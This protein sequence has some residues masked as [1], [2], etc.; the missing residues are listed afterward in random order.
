MR[1]G[2][3]KLLRSCLHVLLRA[4]P[5]DFRESYGEDLQNAYVDRF[6]SMRGRGARLA[7][8][9]VVGLA[10]RHSLRDGV[11]E[12]IADR[13]RQR[14]R[15]LES[16]FT[17]VRM[18]LR[19]LRRAPAFTLVAVLILA[20]GVGANVTAFGA[21]RIASLARPPLPDAE[22][23]VSVDLMR[24]REDGPRYS[25]WAYPY[26]QMLIDW[27]D[28]LIDP[29]AG[30]RTQQVTLTDLGPASQVP[31]EMVSSDY[32][33]VVGIPMAIGRGFTAE[34]GD[35]AAGLRAVVVAHGFWQSRL[36]GDQSVLDREIRLNGAAFRVVGVTP[37]GFSGLGGGADLWV[38]HG[39][40]ELVQPGVLEQ[41]YNHVAWVVGRLRPGA[42]LPAAAAQMES[43]GEAVAEGWPR[44][45]SYRAGVRSFIEIWKNPNA[46]KA[47]TLLSVAAALVLLVA[48]ANLSG[49][50][51]TRARRRLREGAVR[52]ALGASRWRLVRSF[53]VESLT[54]AALGSLAGIGVSL[55]GT[56]MLIVAW[57]AEFLRGTDTGLQVVHPDTMSFDASLTMFALAVAAFAA[58]L[59]GLVPALRA[60]SEH[61]TGHLKET[62]DVSGRRRRFANFDAQTTLVGAQICLALMLVVS[63][64]LLG[65]SVKRLLGVDEGFRTE[66]LLTFDY[67]SPQGV[68]RL[69]PTDEAAWRDFIAL[70]A[71]FDDRMKQRFTALPGIEGMAISAAPMLGG[72]QAVVGVTGI[73][74]Q[75][76]FEDARSIGVVTVDD[77]CFETLGIPILRGRGFTASDGLQSE[78]VV[79]LNETAVATYFRDQDP[80]GQ[81]IGIV[82]SLPGRQMA[83]VVGIVGDM[84]HTG[85]DRDRWP[86][87]YFST[88]ERRHGSHAMIRTTGDPAASI[89]MIQNELYAMDPTIAMSNIATMDQLIIQSVGDRTMILVL[90]GMFAGITVLLVAVGTWG[91]VAFSVADRM[92]ELVLRVALGAERFSVVRLVMHKTTVTALVGVAFGLGGAYAGTRI[93]EAFLW[94]TSA[95]DPTTFLLGS[96]FL[97]AVV[98]VASYLPARQATRMDP[99]QVL[100]AVE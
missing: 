38:P 76:P 51:L 11:L 40:Y 82:F 89:R 65:N 55:W 13:R 32:F 54:L 97:L 20:V 18:A 91:V 29:V 61:I 94:N 17:D 49:I 14:K 96:L 42:T 39:A 98:L 28:R 77:E 64:G 63:V 81:R 47:S 36:G 8:V 50:M 30:Y 1:T 66:R 6:A 15:A 23:L 72:F 58:L 79:V 7:L 70:S 19:S 78:P 86:V 62:A 31:V 10:V 35:P 93:L 95:H 16:I 5:A 27:D 45:D 84:L 53:L 41:P 24:Q 83:E 33:R 4:Y 80:I 57:P 90:L 100:R 75:P 26:L 68:P 21:L 43:I 71:E 48:C 60:S 3:E 44:S 56:R 52:R 37:R 92:R 87:A 74:G 46:R 99:A 67:T 9:R 59:T 12:R 22:R 34:E 85:P 2:E 73:E 69:D 88:R 25:R